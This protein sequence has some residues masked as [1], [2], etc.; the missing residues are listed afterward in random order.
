MADNKTQWL[1]VGFVAAAIIVGSQMLA[2]SQRQ[3]SPAPAPLLTAATTT[4]TPTPNNA[5]CSGGLCVADLDGNG[6]QEIIV[7]TGCLLN[8]AG[9]PG[10]GAQRLDIFNSDGTKRAA[11]QVP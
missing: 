9:C 10:N 3:E 5:G 11:I 2:W 8:G 1:Q 7:L 6:K 4:T